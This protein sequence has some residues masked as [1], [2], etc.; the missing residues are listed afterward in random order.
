MYLATSSAGQG[1]TIGEQDRSE[2]I[3]LATWVVLGVTVSVFI[4]RQVMKALVFRKVA[5]D[6]FFIFAATVSTS[7]S[8]RKVQA[9]MSRCSLSLYLLQRLYQPPEASDFWAR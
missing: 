1:A 9:N 5:L 8:C 7:G 3:S 2:A 6:D 4:A